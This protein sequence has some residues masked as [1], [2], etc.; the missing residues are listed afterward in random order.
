MRNYANMTENTALAV[1]L[2]VIG[3]EKEATELQMKARKK[4]TCDKK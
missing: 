3:R 2:L 4:N 1:L